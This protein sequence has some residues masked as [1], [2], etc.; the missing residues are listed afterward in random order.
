MWNQSL[1][2]LHL[3]NQIATPIRSS[4]ALFRVPARLRAVLLLLTAVAFLAV[5]SRVAIPLGF[6]PVPLAL[7][8]FGV[9]LLGLVLRPRL[10]AAS[11]CTYLLAGAAGL[12]VFAPGPVGL[13][14]LL[15][16]TGGYLLAYPVAVL[17]VAVFARRKGNSFAARAVFAV[18]GDAAILA[19][20]MLMLAAC[21]HLSL[22]AAFSAGVL[23]F[24]PGDALKA[25]AAAGAA[26]GWQR[27]RR[28]P[29]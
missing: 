1:E 9:L 26:T 4:A 8:P 25:I 23:P 16:P 20:G 18:M 13:A 2:E 17:L 21:I 5:C 15:G 11:V 22:A 12:P 14:H 29:K 10:A 27:L 6:T 24:L 3:N 19:G 7:Q 28:T